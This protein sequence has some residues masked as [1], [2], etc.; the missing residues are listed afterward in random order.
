MWIYKGALIRGNLNDAVLG[1][2][3]YSQAGDRSIGLDHECIFSGG[4]S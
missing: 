4:V 2:M 1:R 3:Y